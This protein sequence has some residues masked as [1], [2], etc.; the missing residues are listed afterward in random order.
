LYLSSTEK[1][2]TIQFS[3]GD[4]SDTHPRW[5]TEWGEIAFFS[6]RVNK[7]LPPQI[8]TISRNGGEAR[9]ITDIKGQIS[10]FSWSP[11]GKKLLCSIVKFD[12]E[13]LEREK[14]EKKKELG[15]VVRKYDRLFFK[16]DGFGFLPK[17]RKHIWVVPVQTGKAIQITDHPVYDELDPSWSHDGKK[18]VF[19]SNRS[20]D[21]DNSIF[22]ID[23]FTISQNG[24]ELFK[25]E[26]PPGD[27]SKPVFSPD[28]KWIAYHGAEN[29][30]KM[31]KNTSLWIVPADGSAPARNLTEKYDY[32]VGGGV[33]NDMGH[34]ETMPPT[35]SNDSNFIYFQTSFHGSTLLKKIDIKDGSVETILGEGGEIGSFSF[36]KNQSVMAYFYGKIDDTGQVYLLE[37]TPDRKRKLTKHNENLYRSLELGDVEEVWYKGSAGNDLQGW[38]LKPPGFDPGKKYP[39]ILEIHGGPWAQYGNFFMHEFYYLAA[40]GYVVYYT[41]PRGG[42]G[43]GEQHAGA[44][45]Q[46]WGGPDYEDVMVWTDLVAEK[47]YIDPE[48][49]GVTGGSYGGY[50]TT[51]IIGH[52]DRFKA[53]VAQRCVSNLVSMWGSSDFNWVF[54]QEFGD[55]APFDD[56]QKSW[57]HSPM[58]YMGNAKTPTMLIHSEMD[59]RCAMEQSEQVFVALK[60]LG[61][62][63]KLVRFPDEPH[64]LSRAGRTDRRIVR[65]QSIL[66]WFDRYLKD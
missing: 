20:E 2:E 29:Q 15:V 65:L 63:T 4:Q 25:I 33:I 21:P 16:L 18:I 36:D 24:S 50:M 62:D 3:R 7:E 49:M 19:L 38:I 32:E 26:T 31:Y 23:L 56:F 61:V 37:T 34:A 14:D 47:A 28:G 66:G 53:A 22:E 52:T 13:F 42:R 48:R 54:Q 41:N 6:N 5:S 27:K 64:G 39:S 55:V 44:I 59:L 40:N 57:D 30:G 10:D 9:Q 17:E 35:W 45:S 11:D 46:N 8:F 43:Y 51:W 1:G 60:R 12:E 58:K